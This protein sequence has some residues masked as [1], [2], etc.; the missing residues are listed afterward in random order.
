[1][2][3]RAH[4]CSWRWRFHYRGL[5]FFC[6]LTAISY[7][8]LAYLIYIV[9]GVLCAARSF[10]SFLATVSAFKDLRVD[11]YNSQMNCL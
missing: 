3:A 7:P 8:I 2:Q 6:A 10:S 9:V 11:S 1:M 5:R 4:A